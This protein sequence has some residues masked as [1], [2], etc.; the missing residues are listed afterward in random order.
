LENL[1]FYHTEEILD[2]DTPETIHLMPQDE[3]WV[4]HRSNLIAKLSSN[5]IFCFDKQS[6]DDRYHDHMRKLL[7]D[8][9][10]KDVEFHFRNNKHT[11]VIKA[12]KSVLSA[13][14]DYFEA[15]F[16]RS[17][18]NVFHIQHHGITAF[19]RA[20]EYIYTNVI[21]MTDYIAEDVISLFLVANEYMIYDLRHMCS[22]K[23]YEVMNLDNLGKFMVISLTRENEEMRNACVHFVRLHHQQLKTNKSFC[24]DVE[25]YPEIGI[26]LLEAL[27]RSDSRQCR[28]KEIHQVNYET[29]RGTKRIRR[30][31]DIT[32]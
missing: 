30:M 25:Q 28:I 2:D 9:S 20:L 1:I 19:R 21:D 27:T 12:H 8:E 11:E 17:S 15:I 16:H 14:S 26:F 3:I 4:E 29:V 24:Y 7:F 31:N 22:V 32:G 13:R 5:N 10:G 18:S 6:I 23:S